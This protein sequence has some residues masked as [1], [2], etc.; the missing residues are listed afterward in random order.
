M[1]VSMAAKSLR[2]I[3]QL[4]VTLQDISPPIWR[5]LLVTSTVSLEDLHIILQIVMGWTDS[6]MHEFAKGSDRY[7]IPDEY[8]SSDMHDEATYRLD[9][10]L[11]E[12][13]EKLIYTYDFGDSWEHEV[14]LEKIL[15]FETDTVLPVCLKGSRACPPEDIGGIGGYEM[16]LD[17]IS[18]PSHPEHENMLEWIEGDFDAEHFDLAE[19]N[20]LLRE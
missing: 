4:K 5:R 18:D 6:H 8:S 11:Q 10:V 2:S 1:E 16:F 14:L 20:D 15:P 13:K 12:E 19:V 9:Q 7:G 17:A 3:Y